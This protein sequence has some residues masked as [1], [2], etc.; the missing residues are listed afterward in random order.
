MQEMMS[1]VLILLSGGVKGSGSAVKGL[2]GADGCTA[3]FLGWNEDCKSLQ[4]RKR[5]GPTILCF[6]TSLVFFFLFF[7]SS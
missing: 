2:L 3:W 4:G 6:F 5:W 7:F 1:V